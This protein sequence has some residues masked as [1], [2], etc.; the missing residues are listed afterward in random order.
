MI[1]EQDKSNF[2]KQAFY[3]SPNG[4]FFLDRKGKI[5]E[6]N[7]AFSDILKISREK[8]IGKKVFE[9]ISEIDFPKEKELFNKLFKKE[10]N[11]L[12]ID[13]KLSF[14]GGKHIWLNIKANI[15][16]DSK[17]RI[18]G[19]L[20]SVVDV[21]ER[22]N[23]A[24]ELRALKD[25]ETEIFKAESE[26]YSK[27]IEIFDWKQT[28]HSKNNSIQWMDFVIQQIN[29]AMVQ[30][31]G[32]GSLL[33]SLSVVF[34]KSKINEKDGEYHIKRTIFDFVKEG[35]ETA[36]KLTNCL[37]MAQ[38]I[39]FQKSNFVDT[40]GY[41][42]ELIDVFKENIVYLYD[43]SQIKNQRISIADNPS[44]MKE[45]VYFSKEN[46]TIV[47]R[48]LLINAMK[49]SPENSRIAILLFKLHDELVIKI[50]NPIT[51][52][53]EKFEIEENYHFIPFY[54]SQKIIDERYTKEEFGLGLGLAVVKKLVELNHGKIY[55]QIMKMNL[56]TVNE[57]DA[58]ITIHL[59][60]L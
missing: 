39:I 34:S 14:E 13:S 46:F 11:Q 38:E 36:K 33:S 22:I 53:I 30:G 52:K 19:F 57:E 27:A 10:I 1:K 21:T 5:L 59:P 55:F 26:I 16:Y 47:C 31:N 32:I 20:V 51:Q 43:M 23:Y 41:V 42:S 24:N 3:L 15:I 17:N 7:Y 44:V 37:Y 60:T 50:I 29:M 40:E 8:L 25:K 58:C 48:E 54:R 45:R 49:Y 18:P 35:Y 2:L 12:D 56:S 9:L 28:V 4:F 6:A